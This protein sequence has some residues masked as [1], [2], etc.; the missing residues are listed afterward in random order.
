[1]VSGPVR[2]LI[3]LGSMAN[4]D[5][6]KPIP[7]PPKNHPMIATAQAEAALPFAMEW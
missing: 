5:N 6:F 2:L 4:R 7:N 3:D 1:M